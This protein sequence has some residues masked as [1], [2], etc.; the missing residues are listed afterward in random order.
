MTARWKFHEDEGGKERA[1]RNLAPG[2]TFLTP[3]TGGSRRDVPTKSPGTATPALVLNSGQLPTQ[4]AFL[5]LGAKGLSFLL[6]KIV[7]RYSLPVRLL[8]LGIGRRVEWK[9]CVKCNPTEPFHVLSNKFHFLD[10]CVLC[11]CH[12]HNTVALLWNPV[13]PRFSWEAK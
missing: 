1:H 5:A 11:Q 13:F 2:G 12:T 8:T 7:S 9:L 4:C 10:Y 3:F 6:V